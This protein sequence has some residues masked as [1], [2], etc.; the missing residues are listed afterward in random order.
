MKGWVGSCDMKNGIR[1]GI[2]YGRDGSRKTQVCFSNCIF[3]ERKGGSFHT[4]GLREWKF[5]SVFEGSEKDII[6]DENSGRLFVMSANEGR[7][8]ER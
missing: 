5:A 7:F 4:G 8:A 1:A 2:V 6:A 3:L